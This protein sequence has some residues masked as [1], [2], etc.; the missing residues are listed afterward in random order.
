MAGRIALTSARSS[1]RRKP[2][3]RRLRREPSGDVHSPAC[4]SWEA[5]VE[6]SYA[7]ITEGDDYNLLDF[8]DYLMHSWDNE[9]LADDPEYV[10]GGEAAA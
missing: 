2:R 8:T 3:K 5:H 6:Q 1:R 10:P 9:R 4:P 7:A